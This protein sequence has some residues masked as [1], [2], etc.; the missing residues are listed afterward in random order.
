MSSSPGEVSVIHSP[1]RRLRLEFNAAGDILRF[2]ERLED[3]SAIDYFHRP[4]GN[5]NPMMHPWCNRVEK[6]E[7]TFNGNAHLLRP[8]H[9]DENNA[10][11]GN[12]TLPW[13][14]SEQ[15]QCHVVLDIR[16]HAQNG[17]LD[18]SRKTPYE[19]DA[20]QMLTLTNEGLTVDMSVTNQG[21]SLPFGIGL[22]PF[23]ARPQDTIVRM[24]VTQMENCR[25][26]M[27]PDTD[28]PLVPVPPE[29]TLCKGFNISN[30]NLSPA[31]RGFKNADLMDNCFPGIDPA[32]GATIIWPSFGVEGREMQ[33]T[34]SD[35][36]TYGVI[37][38]PGKNNDAPPGQPSFFCLELTTNGINMQNRPQTAAG[39]TVLG[40]GETLRASTRYVVRKI[41]PN[42]S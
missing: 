39:G 36:C 5:R 27:I 7:F 40:A 23:L 38:V 37:F 41:N 22:H 32:K 18:P 29:W 30:E 42:V 4:E 34:A 10:L 35:N 25:A 15:G 3:G 11:H 28:R 14:I 1:D 9:G 19:Y 20:R 12:W 33:I 26:D 17:N 8:L 2:C 31:S 24:G 21:K 6:G 13:K 16:C